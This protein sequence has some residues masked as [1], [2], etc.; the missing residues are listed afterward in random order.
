MPK[1]VVYPCPSCGAS[2]SIDEGA[3]STQCPFCGN[4]AM[5]PESLR[6]A[7]PRPDAVAQPTFSYGSI[8]NPPM[9]NLQPGAFDLPGYSPG[10]LMS[11]PVM[12]NS[13]MSGVG[14]AIGLNLGITAV[15]EVLTACVMPVAMLGCALLFGFGPFLLRFAGR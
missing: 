12:V 13:R 11:P 6:T 1:I 14:A 5:L 9:V 4:T 3:A 10:V 8:S 15:V 7:A 2:L